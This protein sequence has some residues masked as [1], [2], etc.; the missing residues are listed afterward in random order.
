[1]QIPFQVRLKNGDVIYGMKGDYV[2]TDNETTERW[3][4]ASD[5]FEDTY[6][7]ISRTQV[8]RNKRNRLLEHYRFH[9]YYKVAITWARQLT[10]PQIVNTL[11]GPVSAQAGEYLCVGTKG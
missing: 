2:C 9:L 10:Q 6:R 5:I 1:M 4:V 11:E 7:H 3:I 8:P